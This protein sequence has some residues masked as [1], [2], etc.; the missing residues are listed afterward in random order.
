MISIPYALDALNFF[1]ADVRNAFGP[2]VNVFLVTERHWSQTDVGLVATDER[3]ARHCVSDPD[4]RRDRRDAARSAASSSSAMAA[5]A[6]ASA[7][8]FRRSDLLADG[9]RFARSG[10]R[11]RRLRARGL[12][13]D[14]W[15]GHER[16]ARPASRP[17]LR[18][19]SRRQHRDRAC[20]GRGRLRVLAARG[21]SH[22]PGV[23]RPDC[24]GRAR[25]P[26]EAPSIRTGREIL[27]TDGKAPRTEHRRPAIGVL[28]RTRPLDDFRLLRVSFS[29]SPMRRSCRSSGRNSLFSSRRRRPR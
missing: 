23:R 15:P 19:R 9:G 27:A 4:R 20:G 13:V 26:G 17:Q 12:G 3:I 6:V 28:F 2:F 21:L 18:V 5:M 8:H 22:G 14:P 11:G 16:S 1:A 29:I 24:G 7:H 25:H 10:G